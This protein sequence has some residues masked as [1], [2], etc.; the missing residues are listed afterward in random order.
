MLKNARMIW[1]ITLTLGVALATYAFGWLAVVVLSGAW[2]YIRKDDP[3]MPLMAGGAGVLGW[4]LLLL[5]G[6]FS[7][8]IGVVAETVGA[9]MQ[10]G[11]G[12]L[13]VLTLAFPALL[14]AATAGVVRGVLRTS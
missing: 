12:S 13:L 4:A 5:W 1:F 11:G 8:P 7:G 6:S 2:A 14:A 10:V 9:A 3:A